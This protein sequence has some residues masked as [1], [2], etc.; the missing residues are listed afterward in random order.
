[1]TGKAYIFCRTSGAGGLGHVGGA[2]QLPDGNFRCFGTENPTGGP[3]VAAADKGFWAEDCPESMVVPKFGRSRTLMGIVCPPYNLYKIKIQDQ[4]DYQ[5][6]IEKLVWCSNEPYMIISPAVVKNR[7]CLD[8]VCDTLS[9]YR[10]W[11]PWPITY[12]APNAWF[13]S[14]FD[15]QTFQV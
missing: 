4:P 11:M 6:A 10:L 12:P 3:W 2:F 1:M 5:A 9:A 15:N 14:M 13:A 7:T 8:D